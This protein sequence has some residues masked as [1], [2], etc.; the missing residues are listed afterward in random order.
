MRRRRWHGSSRSAVR[1]CSSA[2]ALAVTATLRGRI[3]LLCCGGAVVERL[4]SS[5]STQQASASALS[6]GLASQLVLALLSLSETTGAVGQWRGTNWRAALES[7]QCAQMSPGRAARSLSPIGLR[8]AALRCFLLGPIS[9]SGQ[10]TFSVRK[11]NRS[12]VIS[13]ISRMLQCC[14]SV[15]HFTG[16]FHNRLVD[17]L[18]SATLMHVAPRCANRKIS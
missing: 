5:Y 9:G 1:I 7:G 18:L 16:L 2:D 12:V 10:C 14:V 17:L 13:N 4:E 11:H 6:T 8:C 15:A 3:E